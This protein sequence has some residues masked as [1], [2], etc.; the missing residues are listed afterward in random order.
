MI[1]WNLIVHCCCSPGL[2]P[3]RAGCTS[4]WTPSRW[5]RQCAGAARR[6]SAACTR[7]SK[8]LHTQISSKQ[9]P[10][11]SGSIID[12]QYAGSKAHTNAAKCKHCVIWCHCAHRWLPWSWWA[13][14]RPP[15]AVSSSCPGRSP[16]LAATAPS[17][18]VRATTAA[19]LM[20]EFW[21]H[22][23]VSEFCYVHYSFGIAK[24]ARSGSGCVPGSLRRRRRRRTS[25]GWWN[26]GR[27]RW[28]LRWLIRGRHQDAEKAREFPEE[29]KQKISIL[30]TQHDATR[31]WIRVHLHTI[32]VGDLV[33][34]ERRDG[35]EAADLAGADQPVCTNKEEN[36]LAAQ[37]CSP[38][39]SVSSR[40]TKGVFFSSTI[41]A[42]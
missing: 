15:A 20:S 17:E 41:L 30:E 4:R 23:A 12:H 22:V 9:T 1:S 21:K 29:K 11:M 25:W 36:Y 27:F 19:I 26:R 14:R 8:T 39:S 18:T 5:P 7:C 34:V 32:G 38:P 31:R 42:D 37:L 2:S 16:A 40:I 28:W 3:C 33:R 13:S 10:C 6:G 24:P 35:L